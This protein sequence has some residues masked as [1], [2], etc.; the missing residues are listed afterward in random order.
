MRFSVKK[1][2]PRKAY[3]KIFVKSLFLAKKS[4]KMYKK[5]GHFAF[6]LENVLILRNPHDN[7]LL[8]AEQVAF[9]N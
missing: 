1:P 2:Q 7:Y 3:L 8:R 6:L 4:T 9:K 5:R